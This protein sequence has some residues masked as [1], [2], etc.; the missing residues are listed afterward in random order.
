MCA[1]ST[2]LIQAE[3]KTYGCKRWHAYGCGGTTTTAT[4]TSPDIA[5]ISPERLAAMQYQNGKRG[6]SPHAAH[7][8]VNSINNPSAVTTTTTHCFCSS[9]C[10]GHHHRHFNRDHGPSDDSPA[11]VATD[12]VVNTSANPV[13]PAGSATATATPE[14]ATL[15]QQAKIYLRA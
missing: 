14:D 5:D 10:S 3:E 7:A 1:S 15:A 13:M 2:S 12:N 9:R 8:G 4:A 6:F 11:P